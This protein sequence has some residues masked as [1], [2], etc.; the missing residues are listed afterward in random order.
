M[1]LIDIGVNLT[2]KRLRFDAAQVIEQ[3]AG[4]GVRQ[5][6]VTGTSIEHSRLAI[7]LC[8]E[9]PQHLYST[10]GIHPHDAKDWDNDSLPA[11]QAMLEHDCVRAIGETGL[12]FN[13][14]F[15]PKQ[16]QIDVFQQQ[17]ELAAALQKPVFLHQREAFD[18]FH[19][20]LREYR[21]RLPNAVAHCFTDDKKALYALLD[22]DCHIGI[23]G[24]ICDERRGLELQQLVRDIPDHRL[25]LE[26][27]APY[28]L[29][30]DLPHKVSGNL[31]LPA[32]LPHILQQVARHMDRSA[33]DLAAAVLHTSCQF[34]AIDPTPA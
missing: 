22:L 25:M 26:T 14:M 24:W 32:Y 19:S 10:C 7:E 8:E 23:T 16:Q 28:L 20:L 5:M 21:D 33:E 9:F 6:V 13:R 15:S 27:D 2:N 30:R 31:N 34:F 29:P 18:S 11:M 17:L 1:Q 12:D 4:V 3:A